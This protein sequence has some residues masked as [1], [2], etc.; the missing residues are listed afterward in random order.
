M[1]EVGLVSRAVQTHKRAVEASTK[2]KRGA[3]LLTPSK[4]GKPS[5]A[6]KGETTEGINIIDF[7]SAYRAEPM[8]RVRIV[9]QGIAANQVA[10]LSRRMSLPQDRLY[11]VLGLVRAT[12]NRKVREGRSLSPDESSRVLGMASLLGQVQVMVEQSGDPTDFDAGAWVS[13][14]LEQPVPAL[15]DRRPSEL[16]DTTEGQAIVSGLAARMQSGAYS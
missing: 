8:E 15:G 5:P 16:M 11:Q 3:C 6:R 12:V 10:A 9:K 7:V 13:S 4:Q 14:W 2:T 1:H